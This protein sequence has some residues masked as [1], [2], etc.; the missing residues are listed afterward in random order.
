MTTTAHGALWH[1]T[2]ESFPTD[3]KTLTASIGPVGLSVLEIVHAQ[4]RQAEAAEDKGFMAQ[5]GDVELQG[6]GAVAALR[7]LTA[8]LFTDGDEALA[9]ALLDLYE[10]LE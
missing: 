4:F 5:R 2:P 10:G 1:L 3:A 7:T 8:S 9:Q 6:H